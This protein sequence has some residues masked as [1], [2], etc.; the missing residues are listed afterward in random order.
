[1]SNTAITV[2]K[3]SGRRLLI[4]RLLWSLLFAL[5]LTLLFASLI[6]IPPIVQN[7]QQTYPPGLETILATVPLLRRYALVVAFYATSFLVF[8]QRSEDARSAT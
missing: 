2:T 8:R 1:V 4:G 3:L 7:I 5:C 6:I